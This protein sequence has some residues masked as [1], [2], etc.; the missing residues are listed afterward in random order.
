M[1]Y[2]FRGKPTTQKKTEFSI[3]KDYCKCAKN[4]RPKECD[5]VDCFPSKTLH[6]VA[7]TWRPIV[8]I[9]IL[10][11]EIIH[12]ELTQQRRLLD[13]KTSKNLATISWIV[14]VHRKHKFEW[15]IFSFLFCILQFWHWAAATRRALLPARHREKAVRWAV[16]GAWS[17]WVEFRKT[18]AR[19][20]ASSKMKYKV[21]ILQKN[22]A[23]K[24]TTIRIDYGGE[25]YDE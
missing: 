23:T 9:V 13:K 25:G 5:L 10:H 22:L 24:C 17:T 18:C 19:A 20:V 12:L 11:V 4:K 2:F 1:F 21:T 3:P 7:A 15:W 6:W 14:I 8:S 16:M